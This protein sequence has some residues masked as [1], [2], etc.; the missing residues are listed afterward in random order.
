[1]GG[2]DDK[3]EAWAVEGGIIYGIKLKLEIAE[4]PSPNNPNNRGHKAVYAYYRPLIL[5]AR[6]ILEHGHIWGV[7]RLADKPMQGYHWG[8]EPEIISIHKRKI[9]KRR[10]ENITEYYDIRFDHWRFAFEFVAEKS[11]TERADCCWHQKYECIYQIE[12]SAILRE[13]ILVKKRLK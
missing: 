9:R 12:S 2:E 13:N 4:S 3:G 7:P 11:A 1:M 8:G 10:G 5:R 6:R